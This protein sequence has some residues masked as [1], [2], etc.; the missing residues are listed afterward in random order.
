MPAGTLR[1]WVLGLLWA[2]V[3]PGV[4]QFYFF[5]FPNITVG[6]VRPF[7]LRCPPEL[8]ILRSQ[9]VAQLLTFPLGRLIARFLP[10]VR[11]FGQSIN[12]GPFTIKEHVV[13]T[14]MAGVGAVSAYA[15]GPPSDY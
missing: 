2:I 15:V 12:P 4:N 8:N 5:R 6:P 13:V 3:I 9:L 11:I 14:I 10:H 7:S 1:A